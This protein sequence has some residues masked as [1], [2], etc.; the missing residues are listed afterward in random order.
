MDVEVMDV[1]LNE[2]ASHATVWGTGDPSWE[3]FDGYMV[4]TLVDTGEG[5]MATRALLFDNESD[6]IEA[7]DSQCT[8]ATTGASGGTGFLNFL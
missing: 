4:L 6:A 2:L 5:S 1:C 8:T 3:P 7:F